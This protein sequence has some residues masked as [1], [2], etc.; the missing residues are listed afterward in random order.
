MENEREYFDD[1]AFSLKLSRFGLWNSVDRD[2]KGLVTGLDKESV[3]FWSREHLNGFQNSTK[4]Y[5]KKESGYK[6]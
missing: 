5:P 1:G 3:I 4:S 2:G 6:L